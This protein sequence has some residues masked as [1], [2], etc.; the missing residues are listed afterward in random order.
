MEH[1]MSG[2]FDTKGR[3]TPLGDD[4]LAKFDE[5]QRAIYHDLASAAA[6]L[7]AA[8]GEATN[9]IAANR[10]AVA[11]LHAA[12]TAEAKKPKWTQLDELRKTQAQWRSDHR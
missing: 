12:E 6:E 3:F 9:A 2:L 8:N 10:A 1:V 4:V 7:D 5:D 11:A